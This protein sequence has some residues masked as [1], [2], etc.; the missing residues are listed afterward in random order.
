MISRYRLLQSVAAMACSLGASQAMGASIPLPDSSACNLSNG[1]CFEIQNTGTTNDTAI[2]ALGNGSGY[3][4]Q[5]VTQNGTAVQALVT[6]SGTAV[7]A[8]GSNGNGITAS[9]TN[10][11]A[12]FAV[13]TNGVGIRAE[14]TG[15]NNDAVQGFTSADCCSGGYFANS[16][17]GNGVYVT[18]T[19]AG[20]AVHGVN[21]GGWAGYFEGNVFATGTYQSSD[22]RLKRDIA[23]GR[24]GLGALLKLRPVTFKWK[25]DTAGKTQLGLI[26][27]EVEKVIPEVVVADHSGMLSVNYTALVPVMVKAIQEQEATIQKLNSRLAT[28]ESERTPVT[29]SVFP[30]V[31]RTN[32]LCLGLFSLG[33]TAAFRRR[34]K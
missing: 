19:N 6:G 2:Y 12:V 34:K 3:G 1:A 8:A 16:G 14:N 5:A 31:T 18:G 26:A 10:G 7:N 22:A 28:L 27:Q 11:L 32:A 4:V 13:A 33:L 17:A 9:S 29:S 23:D 15:A 30:Q 21:V 20:I 25:N 24:Y